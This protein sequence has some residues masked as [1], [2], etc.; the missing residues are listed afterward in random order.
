MILKIIK[1][2]GE[3]SIFKDVIHHTAGTEYLY[4]YTP[5]K[6]TTFK[7]VDVRSVFKKET[8]HSLY[9]VI[10]MKRWVK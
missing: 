7:R 4:V 8:E 9:E 6:V 5:N 10:N 1:G 3:M 2:C